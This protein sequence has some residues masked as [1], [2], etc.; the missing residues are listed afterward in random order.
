[1]FS[2]NGVRP[3]RLFS[4]RRLGYLLAITCWMTSLWLM[5]ESASAADLGPQTLRMMDLAG[6]VHAIGETQGTRAT[7]IVFLSTECPI[8]RAYVPELN[9]LYQSFA[10]KG[11]EFYGVFADRSTSRI[12]CV[13]F[14]REF[15]IAFPVLFDGSGEIRSRL[16]PTHV[17]EAFVLDSGKRLVYRGRIDDLYRELGRRQRT[18]TTRDLNDAIES[19]VR[20]PSS[21]GD[22]RLVRT[23]PVGCLLEENSASR[24]PVTFR[25]DIAP[26]MY[27]NCT[28]CHR[29][30]EVAPFALST[31]E[32]CAKRS[33]FLAKVMGNGL[34]PPW[35]AVAGHGEFVGNRV[36][37]ASQKRLIQKWID[38]GLAVGDVADEPAPPI[39]SKG[40]RLGEP[41]LVIE[42]PH[43][44]TLAADGNDT[45][46]HYVV[47]IELPEDKTLIG[48]EFQ[49]GNPAIVHHAVVFYDT[50]GAARKKD[51][52]TPEPGY[53]TF[54]SPGIPVAGVVG[55]WTPG[56][57]PRF[58]PEDIGYRIPK[59]VDFFASA[60]SASERE[61]GEGSI[62]DR[63]VL[64]EE[65][66][67]ATSNDVASALGAGDADDRRA[68]RR[69][70]PCSSFGDD[71]A[72]T[73]DAA[74]GVAS[75]ALDRQRN[76]GDCLPSLGG[77]G[78]AS[79]DQGLEFL[80]ARQLRLPRAS[81]AAGGDARLDRRGL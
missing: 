65:G 70:E 19:L 28:E 35:M 3:L 61:G 46:Q 30:G 76:E 31:Y 62:E 44:F 34:M 37:S 45:F 66:S 8:A 27:A 78:A 77:R 47:P 67:R 75:H 81:D 1:M 69:V 48:F 51:A 18:P 54:G 56:M 41:D 57:T 29:A 17:P 12:Q 14:A 39:Y 73:G 5:T 59:K 68:G 42:S 23:D 63:A 71:V 26:L 6:R 52:K 80:L 4:R 11:V 53:Q 21:G 79:L 13:D 15:E 7:A 36:L 58:L 24:G 50:M 38:D 32:D 10:D 43:E 49:P 74:V 40:W 33:E 2:E 55:L 16:E 60:S 25:R 20:S 9:R 72:R 64:R 22:P